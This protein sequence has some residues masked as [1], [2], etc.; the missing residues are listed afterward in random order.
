MYC[1][2]DV[3]SVLLVILAQLPFLF[4]DNL[5]GHRDDG[6]QKNKIELVSS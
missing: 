6:G 3:A 4:V 1:F 5:I 2:G